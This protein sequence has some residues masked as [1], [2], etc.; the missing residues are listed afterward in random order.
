MLV[1]S[2]PTTAKTGEDDKTLVKQWKNPATVVTAFF[3]SEVN[4]I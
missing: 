4:D 2:S 3:D 1:P